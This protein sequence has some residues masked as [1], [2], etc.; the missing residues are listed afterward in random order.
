MSNTIYHIIITRGTERLFST[1]L[2]SE[3]H[4]PD[5]VPLDILERLAAPLTPCTV[6]CHCATAGWN[7]ERYFS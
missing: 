1:I 6:K 4:R 7:A 2:T 5:E 3:T